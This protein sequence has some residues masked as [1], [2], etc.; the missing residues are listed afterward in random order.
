MAS[1]MAPL[2]RPAWLSSGCPSSLLCKSPKDHSHSPLSL[3]LWILT[4]RPSPAVIDIGDF[5]ISMENSSSAQASVFL[6][7]TPPRILTTTHLSHPS[8]LNSRLHALIIIPISNRCFL[9]FHLTPSS[10]PTLAILQ[11]H[12]QLPFID[13]PSFRCPSPPSHPH[14]P[15]YPI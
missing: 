14:F 13:S 12:Q 7:S 5:S 8:Q 15:S 11:P 2:R 1:I 9:F 3:K 6:T 10:T 4:H